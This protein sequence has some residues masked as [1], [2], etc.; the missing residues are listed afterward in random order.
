MEEISREAAA[1]IKELTDLCGQLGSIYKTGELSVL[2]EMNRTIKELHRIQHGSKD[3]ALEAVGEE[4]RVIYANF[5]MIVALLKTTENG[6]IDRAAQTAT[7]RFLHNINTA[8]VNIASMLG[9][10]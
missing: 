3:S 9:L 2:S 1:F 6:E 7:G 10:V 5:D 4:C 8:A